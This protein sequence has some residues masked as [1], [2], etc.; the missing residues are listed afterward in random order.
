MA[1]QENKRSYHQLEP[2]FMPGYYPS[3]VSRR[4]IYHN[5]GQLK[6]P[7]YGKDPG[8]H[9]DYAPPQRTRYYTHQNPNYP[10]PL[11]KDHRP[12]QYV[13]EWGP[14]GYLPAHKPEYPHFYLRPNFFAPDLGIPSSSKENYERADTTHLFKLPTFSRG[15][16]NSRNFY[17]FNKYY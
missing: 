17:P 6:T 14:P 1:F 9:G 12:A 7:Y 10:Y 3:S 16:G 15:L 13:P 8:T 4:G 11:D 2:S 5:M